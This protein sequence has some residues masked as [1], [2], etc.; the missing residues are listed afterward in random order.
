MS[1]AKNM[2]WT[3]VIKKGDVVGVCL[4]VL[5]ML[6]LMCGGYLQSRGTHVTPKIVTSRNNNSTT[7]TTP[8]QTANVPRQTNTTPRQTATPSRQAGNNVATAANTNSN[9]TTAVMELPPPPPPK[10]R[11]A[12]LRLDENDLSTRILHQVGPAYPPAARR[13]RVS[14]VVVLEVRVNEYGSVVNVDVKSGPDLLHQPAADAVKQW[15]YSPIMLDG[16]PIPAVANVR[17]NFNLN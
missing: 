9:N 11:P 8:K 7:N 12:F 5:F 15:K 4:A 14:G 2:E 13:A 6:F 17:V 3:L 16:E 10:P 1:E